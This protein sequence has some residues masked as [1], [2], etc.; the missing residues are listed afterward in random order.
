M[1]TRIFVDNLAVTTT[2][3]EL[4]DWFSVYGNI[5]DV[6]LTVDRTTHKS[7]GSGF[8]TMATPEGARAAIQALNG[9]AIGTGTLAV[10]EARPAD[11]R[12]RLPNGRPIPRGAAGGAS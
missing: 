1:N 10:S 8:V 4:M 2:E 12:D 3:R 6:S 7:R 9:K 5:V 11:K